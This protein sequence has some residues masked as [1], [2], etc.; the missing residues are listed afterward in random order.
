M[1]G[2]SYHHGHLLQHSP[3]FPQ[4]RSVSMDLFPKHNQFPGPMLILRVITSLAREARK[5]FR[6]WR[7]KSARL[8]TFTVS[9]CPPFSVS[10]VYLIHG[11]QICLFFVYSLENNW[12]EAHEANS[13]S[14]F[15]FGLT[16]HWEGFFYYP[17]VIII[18]HGLFILILILTLPDFTWFL[19]SFPAVFNI[20]LYH[21][22]CSPAPQWM[23]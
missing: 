2:I 9:N 22:P 14:P 21:L 20:F 5:T 17:A 3:H 8:S 6:N 23:S 1:S 4:S 15:P 10:G 11:W 16:T 12:L 18:I 19:I 13:G 7:S